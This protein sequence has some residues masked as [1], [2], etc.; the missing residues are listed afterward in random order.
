MLNVPFHGADRACGSTL[1]TVRIID[2]L[3]VDRCGIAHRLVPRI[4]RRA[5]KK[6]DVVST[7]KRV[8]RCNSR[9]TTNSGELDVVPS[10]DV[11]SCA[12]SGSAR[13]RERPRDDRIDEAD[14]G[15]SPRKR[16]KGNRLR[17]NG[18]PV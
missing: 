8:H 12:W 18:S 17:P 16:T 3:V 10:I 1:G 7:E 13:A 5:P 9:P 15:G 2:I 14:R 6:R 4:E 11:R